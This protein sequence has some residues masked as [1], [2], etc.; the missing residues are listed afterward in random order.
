MRKNFVLPL[1]CGLIVAGSLMLVSSSS[2]AATANV[3]LS[4]TGG[5]VTGYTVAQAGQELPVSFTMR[6]HSTTT[7]VSV[8]FT[9]TLSNATADGTDYV[10]NTSSHALINPDTPACEPGFLGAGKTVGAAILVTPTISSGTVRVKA[11]ANDESNNPDPVPSNNCKTVS[12][13][14]R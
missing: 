3:D 13:T 5:T 9:F 14:I 6:N 12:I 7:A 2:G 1:V 10:C 8:D 11:C 4:I